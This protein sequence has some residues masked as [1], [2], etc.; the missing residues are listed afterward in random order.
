MLAGEYAKY[1]GKIYGRVALFISHNEQD[2]IRSA[3]SVA[4]AV[5][6]V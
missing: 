2:C 1:R 4:D 6:L 3:Q 5:V